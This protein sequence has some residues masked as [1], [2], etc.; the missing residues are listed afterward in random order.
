[1]MKFGAMGVDQFM[2]LFVSESGVKTGEA[3][4][5]VRHRDRLDRPGVGLMVGCI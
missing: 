5:Q 1:M 4:D 3:G 2:Y